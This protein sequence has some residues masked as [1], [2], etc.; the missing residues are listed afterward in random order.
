MDRSE[1]AVDRTQ[2]EFETSSAEYQRTVKLHKQGLASASQLEKSQ[3]FEILAESCTHT[4]S[5]R[6]EQLIGSFSI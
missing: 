6:Q 1:S 5:C 4:S 2:V 3:R